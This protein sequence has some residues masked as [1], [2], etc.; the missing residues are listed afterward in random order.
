MAEQLKKIQSGERLQPVEGQTLFV[1]TQTARPARIAHGIILPNEKYVEHYQVDSSTIAPA[2]IMDVRQPESARRYTFFIGWRELDAAM[3]P[4]GG[5]N[6]SLELESE[7]SNTWKT[8]GRPL[9][10]YG[11]WFAEDRL[12]PVR[13]Y[14]AMKT[15]SLF[16]VST[17]YGDRVHTAYNIMEDPLTKLQQEINYLLRRD[18]YMRQA[19]EQGK[20]LW[21]FATYFHDE[22]DYNTASPDFQ[23]FD[24]YKR[25][26][27]YDGL[28]RYSHMMPPDINEMMLDLNKKGHKIDL[29][30]YQNTIKALTQ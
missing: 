25:L 12:D 1:D 3:Q 21:E 9:R 7:E 29:S 15:V 6:P 18:G 2:V 16:P 24:L 27:G 5:T 26:G 30:T 8:L 20:D 17:Y 23:T 28:M 11:C 14:R 13:L 10:L 22:T 4:I 19:L